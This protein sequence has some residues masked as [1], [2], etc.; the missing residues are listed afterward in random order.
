MPA[1]KAFGAKLQ[2]TIATVLTDIA[3]LVDINPVDASVDI[4]DGSSHDSVGE[5]REKLAGFK[6]AGDVKIDMNYDPANTGHQAVEDA[7]AVATAFALKY[8]SAP[9][10]RVT[11]SFSGIVKSFTTGAPHDGKL[12]ASCVIAI[13]GKITWA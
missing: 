6:D 9:A 2:I 13:S 5:W 3:N 10:G 12:T 8:P 4:I 11:G 1:K 7:L